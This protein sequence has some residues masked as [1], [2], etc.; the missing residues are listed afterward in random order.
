MIYNT[1]GIVVHQIKYGE[2]SVVTRVYTELFGLQSYIINGVRVKK[3]KIKS[4][5][6]QPL[7]VLDMGV[8]NR[9]K[10]SLQRVKY[11]EAV[12]PTSPIG[13]NVVKGSLAIFIAEVLYRSIQE[14]EPNQNL[15]DF[16][17]H[18][19]KELENEEGSVANYHLV[20]M[21]ELSGHLGFRP[22]SSFS[23]ED[24][25]FDKREGVF[26]D[27]VPPHGDWMD[28]ESSGLLKMLLTADSKKSLDQNLTSAQRNDLVQHLIAYYNLHLPS[29]IEIKSHKV[30]QTIMQ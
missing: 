21:L 20:F 29:K 19:I 5:I 16:L 27:H 26:C 30:L 2:T 14:E 25:Y 18:F 3:A 1:R 4:N 6:L 23:D 8:Y 11:A 10:R 24:I 17:V 28:I 7:S 13:L 15:F 9:D 22:T 12:N